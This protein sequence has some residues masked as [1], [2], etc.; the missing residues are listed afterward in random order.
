MSVDFQGLKDFKKVIKYAKILQTQI[1]NPG[2][3]NILNKALLFRGVAQ[4]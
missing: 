1:F 3:W 2:Y 4:C